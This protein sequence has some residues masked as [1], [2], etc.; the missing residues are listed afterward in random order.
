MPIRRLAH[1]SSRQWGRF[2][3]KGATLVPGTGT[4]PSF[5]RSCERGGGG[6]TRDNPSEGFFGHFMRAGMMCMSMSI[7]RGSRRLVCVASL[8]HSRDPSWLPKQQ[9][10][11]SAP[12]SA[13]FLPL[14]FNRHTC[15]NRN[16][17]LVVTVL[18]NG[19]HVM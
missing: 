5:G 11:Q 14:Q 17:P 4:V 3:G 6:L 12:S 9:Q 7:V 2:P 19:N 16:P 10:Q 15:Y 8:L 13:S 1:P 18:V